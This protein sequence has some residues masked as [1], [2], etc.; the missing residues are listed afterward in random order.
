MKTANG[1]W[2]KFLGNHLLPPNHYTPGCWQAI[3][4]MVAAIADDARADAL[5]EKPPAPDADEER[6]KGHYG[7]WC[8]IHPKGNCFPAWGVMSIEDRDTWRLFIKELDI[9]P[10]PVRSPGQRLF[11]SEKAAGCCPF[12]CKWDELTTLVQEHFATRATALGI[13]PKE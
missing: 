4:D 6:A 2:N 13:Q 7:R 3:E 10:R 8:D 11:E 9:P 12:P 1:Y 5:A